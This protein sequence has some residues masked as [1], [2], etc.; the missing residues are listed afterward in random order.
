MIKTYTLLII[1]LFIN[2]AAYAQCAGQDT[3][4]TIC[5]YA[6]S[7][8]QNFNLF[9]VLNGNPDSGGTWVD[10]DNL[11]VYTNSNQNEIN[12]W[13]I[14][15][16]GVF[17]FTYNLTNSSCSNTS[18]TLTLIIGGYAG[19]DNYIANACEN[20]VA[21]NLFQF[22]GNNPN[23]HLN[24]EWIDVSNTG[25]LTDNIYDATIQGIGTYTF[26]Y[27]VSAIG[28]CAMHTITVELTVHPL[29]TPS[30]NVIENVI[31]GL[32]E[33][34]NQQDIDLNNYLPASPSNGYWSDNS[35][36]NEIDEEDTIVD[37]Q[38]IFNN[39]GYG[40]YTFSYTAIPSHPICDYQVLSI[41]IKIK[42]KLDFSGANL[43]VNSFCE[44]DIAIPLQAQ[45]LNLP[46][47][48]DLPSNTFNIIYNING[49]VSLNEE[50]AQISFNN[51]ET[52]NLPNAFDPTPGIYTIE[53]IDIASI[54]D[55]DELICE[56]EYNLESTFEIFSVFEEDIDLAIPNICFG[57]DL[58]INFEITNN[59]FSGDLIIDYSITGAN[60]V[61]NTAT[62]NF[63][64]GSSNFQIAENLFSNAGLH[65]FEIIQI[66]TSDG[67]ITTPTDLKMDFRIFDTPEPT[68]F[69]NDIC[70]GDDALIELSNLTG[71]N[72]LEIECYLSGANSTSSQTETI[73]INNDFG[74]LV[75][76]ANLI[77]NSGTTTLII[78][79]LINTATSCTITT[80]INLTFEVLPLPDAP[81][82]TP[83]QEFCEVNDAKASDL[84][85][86]Q[87]TN[88]WYTSQNSQTSLQPET[89]LING[90]YWVA[91]INSNGCYSN[92]TAVNVVINEIPPATLI[93]QGEDFCGVDEPTI[94][95]LSKNT[96]QFNQ[97][98]I[99]WY[100]QNG[101]LLTES[102]L[103]DENQTYLGYTYDP[104]TSCEAKEVLEVNVSL[105]EC[106]NEYDFFIPDAF[107][108]NDDGINDV[109]R[110][111]DIN[112]IY[113]DY[114][115]EI[116][117]RYG[118]LLYQGDIDHPFWNG[119]AE[120]NLVLSDGVVPNGI[121]FYIVK[122]NKNNISPQQGRLYLNR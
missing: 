87:A 48:N 32:E 3:T 75:I 76:P 8:N 15:Q 42:R 31:C 43:V 57:N 80:T 58:L 7:S 51:P 60:S 112:Y 88:L 116:Y 101:N 105:V 115:F 28:T 86:N 107:S 46:N 91:V 97:Y 109:F 121:Y 119:E 52:F 103:L 5:D 55:P 26:T 53:V 49:P 102:T 19:E 39:F 69:V 2:I 73:T 33:I 74:D 9:N 23:P 108:P 85:P 1:V 117:N 61:N 67:C 22:T 62:L 83:L 95:D 16:S 90:T 120:S 54:N 36:T 78:N 68:I 110:I 40:E 66:T 20:D 64:N 44:N 30:S 47:L 89:P 99:E 114:K 45:I 50:T 72:Q 81:N 79:E 104:V 59:N 65:Q 96:S 93:P 100:D 17:T 38:N 63:V 71:I 94:L 113:P 35:G 98:P 106:D 12:I 27:N 24:G 11:G 25:A 82:A 111:P 10:N 18:A 29:P 41:V 34:T 92:K 13:Q 37:V 6:N 84:I 56:I 21:V 122:F 70:L 77:T 14:N 118:K 4:I